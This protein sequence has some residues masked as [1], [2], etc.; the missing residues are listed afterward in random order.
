MSDRRIVAVVNSYRPSAGQLTPVVDAVAAQVDHVIVVDDAS[1]EEF[2]ELLLEVGTRADNIEVLR[3]ERN[4]GIASATNAGIVRARELAATYI[5]HFDQDSLPSSTYVSDLLRDLEAASDAGLLVG[6]VSVGTV[7][8]VGMRDVTLVEGVATVREAIQ[9]GLLVPMSTFEEV[10]LYREG[11][12]IDC[13]DIEL[14][15]RVEAAGM[16]NVVSGATMTHPIGTRMRPTVGGRRIYLG[17]RA[18]EFSYHPAFRRYY[19]TRNRLILF[20]EHGLRHPRW[21][22]KHAVR[23][24]RVAILGVI[25]G[26]H[27]VDQC[28]AI[29]LGLLDGF[30]GVEGVGR[31]SFFEKGE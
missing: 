22:I 6:S 1:G 24:V 11:F 8:G 20:R 31:R 10:G 17:R 21:M 13:V 5:I 23:E 25:F 15:I 7:N 19:I 12:V 18:L 14:L 3:R 28:L 16:V 26:R 4:G 30:R 29:G 2:A 9:S 27:R